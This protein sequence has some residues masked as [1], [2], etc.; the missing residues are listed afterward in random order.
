MELLTRVIRPRGTEKQT[1]ESL[2][3]KRDRLLKEEHELSERIQAIKQS[4]KYW[5]QCQKVHS[6]E[7]EVTERELKELERRRS[8]IQGKLTAIGRKL[9]CLERSDECRLE[10]EDDDDVCSL[11]SG[12]SDCASPI[13]IS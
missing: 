2:T 7:C 12:R 3:C 5:H 9:V 8:K 11:H 4:N 10:D 6:C 1:V 13:I